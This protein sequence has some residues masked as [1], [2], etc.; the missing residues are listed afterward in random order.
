MANINILYHID[1]LYILC[2]S[3]NMNATVSLDEF[4]KNLSDIVGKVM[5][6]NQTVLVQKHNRAGVVVISE[7]EYENLKDPR[8]RFSSKDGWDKLFILTDRVR[9]RMSVRDQAELGKIVD[10]EIKEIRAQ[11]QKAA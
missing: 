2:Y 1:K 8:K 4:R 11:K 10:E 7:R 9:D 6:A 5:Y 3:G